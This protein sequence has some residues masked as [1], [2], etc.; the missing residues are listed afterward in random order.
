MWY[1]SSKTPATGQADPPGGWTV[2]AVY[3]LLL[4][5]L[6][7]TIQW[8]CSTGRRPPE[9]GSLRPALL[10]Q[11]GIAS[12]YGPQF[13]GRKTSS[14]EIFD[15]YELTAAH[16][17][18]PLGTWVEVTNLENQRSVTVRINDRGPFIKGRIID[19]SWEAARVLGMIGKGT[20][21]VRVEVIGTPV[22]DQRGLSAPSTYVIQMGAF[23][24][25]S[26]ALALKRVVEDVVAGTE[27]RLV[28]VQLG[29]RTIYR[30]RTRSFSSREEAYQQA[31]H[32][33]SEG[34]VVIVLPE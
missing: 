7:L 28:P 13:H 21:R 11:E 20:A 6:S 2:K 10:V 31:R 15:M 29:G 3:L 9:R 34:F 32:L 25:R 4:A 1:D 8:G 33:A 22:A 23:E 18:L 14:G 12:W 16:P 5:A 26:N 27:V 17:S 24:N 19:L 30:V